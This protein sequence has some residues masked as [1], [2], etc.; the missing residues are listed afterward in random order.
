MQRL[1]AAIKEQP[2]RK[3]LEE[4]RIS[5]SYCTYDEISISLKNTVLSTED[6][7]FFQHPGFMLRYYFRAMLG[8]LKQGKL[9][10]GG[11]TI[12][13]QL[14]KNLYLTPERTIRRKILELFAAVYLEHTLSK[15]EIFELYLNIVNFG[16]EQYGIRNACRSYFQIEP[17]ELTLNQ[18]I[19]LAC[20]LP[21][22]TW[23]NPNM[24]EGRFHLYLW[25][26]WVL[27]DLYRRQLLTE[28]ELNCLRCIPWD[29]VFSGS[30]DEERYRSFV[31]R[32][33]PEG[34][35]KKLK[36]KCG[37][38]LWKLE[39]A[40]ARRRKPEPG[41]GRSLHLI[42]TDSSSSNTMELLNLLDRY[43][44]K[45]VFCLNGILKD[46]R[47]E[48]I[49][50]RGHRILDG[51]YPRK[52]QAIVCSSYEITNNSRSVFRQVFSEITRQG[53]TEI[54]IQD[55]WRIDNTLVER[56]LLEGLQ[57]GYSFDLIN[58]SFCPAEQ[59]Q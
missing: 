55:I 51:D 5:A 17:S 20:L 47:R 50:K 58:R 46:A 38:L 45:A 21:A 8:N 10:R 57:K 40:Q 36:Q 27:S 29:D 32:T 48:E 11:S 14:A 39:I 59:Q 24:P 22:P 52:D 53:K 44:V 19:S 33:S 56:I 3:V 15:E 7:C 41:R 13:L 49:Q 4:K 23:H 43:G 30:N 2:A 1:I 9:V 54:V 16:N 26:D 12:T 6:S 35:L 34:Y 31:A 42:F 28:S 25:R 37:I 18:A